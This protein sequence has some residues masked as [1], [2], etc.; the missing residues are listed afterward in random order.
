MKKLVLTVSLVAGL[1]GTSFGQGYVTVAGTFSNST[2]TT[3]LGASFLGGTAAGTVGALQ[4]TTAGGLYTMALLTGAFTGVTNSTQLFN[5]PGAIANWLDT[6]TLGHNN[7]FAGR[8]TIGSDYLTTGT[9]AP[10]GQQ[11]QWLLVAWSTSIGATWASVASQLGS[12]TFTAQ[13]AYLGWSLVGIGAAGPPPTATPLTVQGASGSI[14][15]QGMQLLLVPV[16][17]PATIALAGLGGL[18]LLALR[19]KK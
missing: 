15:N 6:G 17:E 16:P 10:V 2:N 11:N 13:N 19:R 4:S 1:I 7:T 14:I 12:G 18:A 5:N 9:V 8:L 3:T